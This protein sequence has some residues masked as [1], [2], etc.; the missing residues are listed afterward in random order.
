MRAGTLAQRLT[1][2]LVLRLALVWLLCVLA[3]A[4]YLN[5]EI[6]EN[7]DAELAESAHRMFDVAMFQLQRT[8]PVGAAGQAPPASAVIADDPLFADA[9]LV[10]QLVNAQGRLLLRSRQAPDQALAVPLA[11]GF[12]DTNQWR[13]HVAQHPEQA[14]FFLLADPLSERNHEWR[15]TLLVLLAAAVIALAALTWA[16]PGVVTR[17]LG[18]LE[19]LQR[20][21]RQRG[22]GDLRPLTLTGLPA[23]LRAVG[24]DVNL[25]LQRLDQALDVERA[26]AANAA[27]ELRTPLAT[28]RLR[29][30]T[31]LEHGLHRDD[32]QAAVDAL[33]T[34][35]HR[36]E[37]LLQ[38]SRAESSAPLTREPVDLARLAATVAQEFWQDERA[39]DRLELVTAADAQ[40]CTALGDFDALAIALRNLVENALHYAAPCPVEIIVGPG[41]MLAVRDHGPGVSADR[42]KS[43]QQR[44]VRQS[45]DRAGY[46]LGLSIV[47]TI[48]A[49]HDARLT[50]TSPLPHESGGFEARMQWTVATPPERASSRAAAPPSAPESPPR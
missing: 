22:G 27:H 37:K 36:T 33:H 50:L 14:L 43:L 46:G 44:H 5:H 13:V 49:K 21:I 45:A 7:F 12:H 6:E 9:P 28:A 42:L 4:Y 26:L 20:Q 47:A 35:S 29:L 19:R 2:A 31:A 23:E 48:A 34:L 38:L 11:P 17:E 24:E 41:P 40:H 3:V 30:Q 15:E 16:L 32:V 39:A 10:Y 25:L 8:A 18:V 1:R